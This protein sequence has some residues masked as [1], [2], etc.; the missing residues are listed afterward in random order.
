LAS[1]NRE[2]SIPHQ[3]RAF[4]NEESLIPHWGLPSP[5]QEK[6]IPHLVLAS[7]NQAKP[8]FSRKLETPTRRVELPG[9]TLRGEKVDP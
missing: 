9:Q 8:A 2:W 4:P 5:N 6:P 3:G 1:P 7:A